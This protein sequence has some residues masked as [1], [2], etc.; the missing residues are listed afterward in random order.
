[1]LTQ[2]YIQAVLTGDIAEGIKQGATEV[3]E[4]CERAI[5]TAEHREQTEQ[6]TFRFVDLDRRFGI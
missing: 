1:M 6:L 2:R 5:R 3:I 4:K